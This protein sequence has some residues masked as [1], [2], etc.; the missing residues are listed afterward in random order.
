MIVAVG[1][2]AAWHFYPP[3]FAPSG[4]PSIAVLPFA[5]L[6]G[7][8]D[9][10]YFSDGLAEDLLTDLARLPRLIVMSRNATAGY[11]GQAV[12]VQRVGRE[13]GVRYMVEGSVQRAG[14]QMRITAQLIE[15]ASNTHIWAERYDRP[16]KDIFAVQDEITGAVAASLLVNITHEDLEQAKRKPPASLSAYELF[17]RGHEQLFAQRPE[18]ITAAIGLFEQAIT[19]D[20]TYADAYG[21]LSTIYLD[22]AA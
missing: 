22:C 16:T 2:A 7:D 9:Q 19:V 11:K 13:L 1:G 17:L 21:Q 8:K 6:S 3:G 5:N 14:D 15:A 18:T 20:P 12:D 10:D 4:F